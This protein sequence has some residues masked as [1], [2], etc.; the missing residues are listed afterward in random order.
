MAQPPDERVPE[1]QPE[2]PLRLRQADVAAR[3]FQDETIILDL[4]GSTYFSTNATGTV[5]WHALERGSTRAELIQALLNE[6][7]VSEERAA[8]DVDA[9][10]AACRQRRLLAEDSR[11]S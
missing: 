6:F 8:A 7:E 5:L 1:S 11:P 10:V 3:K 4:R 9:F 2:P